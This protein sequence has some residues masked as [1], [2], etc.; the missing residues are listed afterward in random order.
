MS[1]NSYRVTN[2]T[3]GFAHEETAISSILPMTELHQAYGI[4]IRK[5]MVALGLGDYTSV[6]RGQKGG[7][8]DF[9]WRVYCWND[10]LCAAFHAA[11]ILGHVEMLQ[12]LLQNEVSV[13]RPF[14]TTGLALGQLLIPTDTS[15][16]KGSFTPSL[17][18]LRDES[19]SRPLH[20]AVLS[21]QV[22]IVRTILASGADVRGENGCGE[23]PIHL[24]AK[25][26]A[27]EILRLLI[28]RGAAIN[29][30]DSL[31]RRPLHHAAECPSGAVCIALLVNAGADIEACTF[32]EPY[33]QALDVACRRDFSKNV[34]ALLALGADAHGRSRVYTPPL[35]TAVS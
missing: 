5:F 6:Q 2:K 19:K 21:K 1:Q 7:H 14:M 3:Q 26:G 27:T 25:R 18:E 20:T 22:S 30:S 35:Q 34:G 28:N 10:V 15:Y 12:I 9:Y 17:F 33:E 4:S 23:H 31:G 13:E 32:V 16:M 8:D 11:I 24:A 29:C